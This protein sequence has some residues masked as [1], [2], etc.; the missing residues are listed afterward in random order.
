MSRQRLRPALSKPC[1]MF[2]RNVRHGLIRTLETFSL[3]MLRLLQEQLAKTQVSQMQFILPVEV[4]TY[5]LN[6]KRSPIETLEEQYDVRILIIPNPDFKIPNYE[7]RRKR[8]ISGKPDKSYKIQQDQV[9]KYEYKA[10]SIADN[11]AFGRWLL[12]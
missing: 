3:S 12:T 5:L 7:F 2:V 9:K 10:R 11:E 4:A 8:Q 6:E 1:N